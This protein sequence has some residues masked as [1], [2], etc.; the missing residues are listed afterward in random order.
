M[1]RT[2][3]ATRGLPPR[4]AR[5]AEEA[6]LS[7]AEDLS[8]LL[9]ALGIRYRRGDAGRKLTASCPSPDHRDKGPSWF[10]NNDP[11]DERFGTHACQSC[12]FRGGPVHLARSADGGTGDWEEAASLLVRLFVGEAGEV[13]LLLDRAVGSRRPRGSS[14]PPVFDLPALGMEPS[15]GTPGGRYLAERGLSE[16]MQAAIGC[17]WAPK[18]TLLHRP[19]ADPVD[20]GE[21][22]VLPV[23]DGGDALC[24]AARA[25]R[26]GVKPKYLYPPAPRDRLLWGFEYW[27]P[28]GRDVGLCEGIVDAWASHVSLRLPVYAALGARLSPA[29]AA[30][31]RLARSVTVIPDPNRAGDRLWMDAAANLPGVAE[32]RVAAA[33]PRGQDAGDSLRLPGDPKRLDPGLL[34][35]AFDDARD[36]RGARPR[37]VT[38]SYGRALA[39]RLR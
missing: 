36:A 22:A 21:R 26:A 12:T 7:V 34:R 1:K 13:D 24:F 31:L 19:D 32:V 2:D 6:A 14:A 39:D 17:M 37:A 16:W 9:D 15:P 33:L 23:L 28:E 8:P 29:A 5:R 20:V 3:R 10:V 35:A 11:D 4:E 18:G 30:R 25:V 27:G 38:V